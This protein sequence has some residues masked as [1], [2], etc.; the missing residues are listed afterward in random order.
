MK[1]IP[2]E[3]YF[4]SQMMCYQALAESRWPFVKEVL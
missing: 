3:V 1:L 2:Y 4:L